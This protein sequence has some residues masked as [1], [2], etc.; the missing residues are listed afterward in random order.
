MLK[1]GKWV[2]TSVTLRE[3]LPT[4]TA[5]VTGSKALSESQAYPVGFGRAFVA[6]MLNPNWKGAPSASAEAKELY[7]RQLMP[8][9][10]QAW[11]EHSKKD[12]RSTQAASIV[13]AI[14][15]VPAHISAH[16]HT[17]GLQHKQ[18]TQ[19]QDGSIHNPSSSGQH[20]SSSA[21]N[22]SS[23]TE[24]AAKRMRLTS[25]G[26]PSTPPGA[27]IQDVPAATGK[28]LVVVV[29]DEPDDS[30]RLDGEWHRAVGLDKSFVSSPTECQAPAHQDSEA[31]S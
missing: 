10:L 28:S 22:A 27:P 19:A 6:S 11:S 2:G 31:R 20:A 29:E 8:S 12:V 25:S 15:D 24:H 23:S 26:P 18:L 21:H 14:A 7:E 1:T 5:Q 4:G 16:A 17:V 3:Q 30:G 9:V 13:Q